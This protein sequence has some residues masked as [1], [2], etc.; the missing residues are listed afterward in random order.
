MRM[1]K[2]RLLSLL[3]IG[4]F[5]GSGVITSANKNKSEIGKSFIKIGDSWTYQSTI[6]NNI[7]TKFYY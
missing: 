7:D 5:I 6:D 1:S 4:L 3:I 2:T